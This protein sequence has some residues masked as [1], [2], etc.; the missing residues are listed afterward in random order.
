MSA[1]WA[2]Q[3][4]RAFD[5]VGAPCAPTSLTQS[6]AGG[7]CQAAPGRSGRRGFTCT[8]CDRGCLTDDDGRAIEAPGDQIG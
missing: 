5:Q 1:S 6:A 4:V 3:D 2:F 7:G 8:G